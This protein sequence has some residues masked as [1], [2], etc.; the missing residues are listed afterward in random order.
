MKKVVCQ[1]TTD[2]VTKAFGRKLADQLKQGGTILLSGELGAGKTTFVQGLGEGLRIRQTLTSPTFTLMNVYPTTHP[3]IHTLIHVDLYRL[4]ADDRLAELD[5][6]SLQA[7]PHTL[8][9]IE[10]PE[11]LAPAYWK[12]ILGTIYF[13]LG[14]TMNQRS[15]EVTGTI[16]PLFN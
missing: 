4:T 11:R 10:W 8:L 3:T 15:L 1:S 6:P 9:V 16:A 2:G 12:K 14:D 7:D 5:L 13:K